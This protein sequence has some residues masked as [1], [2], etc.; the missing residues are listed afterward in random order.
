[1]ER[2]KH[3]RFIT[4]LTT[5]FFSDEVSY[6]GITS[7]LSQNGI[8]IRT[9]NGVPPN[10]V[11]NIELYMPDHRVALLKGI[12]R[13]T[14]RTPLNSI[15]NGMGIEIIEHNETFV[16]FVKSSLK[17]LKE[18]PPRAVSPECLKVPDADSQESAEILDE[19]KQERRKHERLTI[20][21]MNVT[22]NMSFTDEI[23]IVN[24]SRDGIMMKTER[25]L[26]IGNTYIFKLAFEESILSVKARVIWCLLQ[27]SRHISADEIVPVYSAGL[28]FNEVPGEEIDEFVRLIENRKVMS[29]EKTEIDVAVSEPS[30][31]CL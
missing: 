31:I 25:R 2:R 7:D 26:N 4:R 1:M 27:E 28:Q 30:I 22:A 8:Y 5:K 18:T 17:T 10:T 13:R 6:M 19:P 14:Y 16:H 9:K 21:E 20:A 3:P 29:S 15:K 23:E 12:V 24:I 11:I